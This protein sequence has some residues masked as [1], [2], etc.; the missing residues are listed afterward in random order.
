[1]I[2]EPTEAMNAVERVEK[3]L[4][5]RAGESGL[6]IATDTLRELVEAAREPEAGKLR[7]ALEE[8]LDAVGPEAVKRARRK[9]TAALSRNQGR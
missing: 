1:M 3:A 4:A 6:L 5:D 8:W 2:P 7:E 9:A